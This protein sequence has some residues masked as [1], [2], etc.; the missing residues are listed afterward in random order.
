MRTLLADGNFKQEH[1]KMKAPHD[2]VALSDGHAYIVTKEPF[3][4]YISE[5][6]PLKVQVFIY[7]FR[8]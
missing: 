1:L 8:A 4:R 6:P 7:S 5:A 2:D 3:D